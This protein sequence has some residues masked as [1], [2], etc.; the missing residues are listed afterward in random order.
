L[1]I[2]GYVIMLNYLHAIVAHREADQI[3]GV[4][5]DFKR[6]TSKKIN[7][8]LKNHQLEYK[9]LLISTIKGSF[10]IHEGIAKTGLFPI[11]SNGS[12][13]EQANSWTAN[14][15]KSTSVMVIMKNLF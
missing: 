4:I 12:V 7:E 3:P 2:L 8:Y 1:I 15:F 5:R 9:K 6:H 10:K 14:S 11:I 13:A